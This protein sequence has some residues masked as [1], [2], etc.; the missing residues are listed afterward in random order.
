MHWGS[1]PL[2]PIT[3]AL[4][5]MHWGPL[6]PWS[7]QERVWREGWREYLLALAEDT[8]RRWSQDDFQARVSP[9]PY[10]D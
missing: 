2:K 5:L 7:L 8:F 10:D 1:D 6:E 4:A 9:P 3:Y